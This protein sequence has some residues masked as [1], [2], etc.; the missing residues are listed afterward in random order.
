MSLYFIKKFTQFG[1]NVSENNVQLFGCQAFF[2]IVQQGI[3]WMVFITNQ[4]GFL[5]VHFYNFFKVGCKY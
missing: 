3:V 5:A 4:V 2:I 1:F